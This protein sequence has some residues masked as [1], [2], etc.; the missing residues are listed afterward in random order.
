L[1]ALGVLGA[2]AGGQTPAENQTPTPSIGAAAPT[3]TPTP[4]EAAIASPDASF[5]P[6]G[7][8]TQ[9]RVVRVIDGDTIV[10]EFGGTEYHLRYIGMDTPESVK[11]NTPVQP[12]A[13]EASKANEDLVAGQ[14]VILEKEVSETD[15]FG[16]L[17]RDVWVDRDGTLVMVGL[18]LVRKGYA[19]V[20]TF[21]PDVQYVEE[22]LAAERSARSGSVGLWGAPPSQT[23]KPSVAAVVVDDPQFI[24]SGEATN[25]KGA[26]GAYSWSTVTFG[27]DRLVV[28]WTVKAASAACQIV[29]RVTPDGGKSITRTVRAKSS[30]TVKGVERYDTPF[31]DASLAVASTCPS[32]TVTMQGADAPPAAADSCHPSYTP[33]LP[34]VDDLDCPDV[35]AMGKAPVRIKGPDVYR[36]DR[37]G[38]GL[39]CE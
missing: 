10:V 23:P 9:A 26:Q 27:A 32:W 20:T 35:K 13:L 21:P 33:C 6:I 37:D 1:L 39:G 36:L 14:T 3:F 18:E 4:T 31:S 11:P 5:A 19:Q 28:R 30:Q 15:S 34:I 7:P 16:R 38:D 12:L 22:L 25:F 17:L 8:T 29:L 2:I 24:D